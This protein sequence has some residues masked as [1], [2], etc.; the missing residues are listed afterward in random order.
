MTVSTESEF[1]NKV[2]SILNEEI[3]R[4]YVLLRN[5]RLNESQIEECIRDVFEE[6]HTRRFSPISFLCRSVSLII[7]VSKL[8]LV[9]ITIYAFIINDVSTQKFIL[10]HSQSYI[11]PFMRKLRLITIPLLNKWPSISEF[12]EEQCLVENPFFVDNQL[13]C[14]PCEDVRTVVD[15]SFLFNYSKAYVYNEKP[16]FVRDVFNESIDLQS[17]RDLCLA[18]EQSLREGTAHFKSN[19]AQLSMRQFFLNPEKYMKSDL[20]ITW[21]MSRVSAA[22]IIRKLFV[23]PHFVPESSEIALQRYLYFDGPNSMSYNF[24][25]TDFANV[26]LVQA[27]GYRLIALHPSEACKSNCTSISVLL[28]PKD[29]LYYNWQFYS[30]QSLPSKISNEMSITYLSSFY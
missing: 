4:T 27:Q 13:E 19:V 23:K 24:P 1:E 10:R 25:I 5:C 3:E 2:N 28:R 12:H 29:V 6:N 16:F 30:A 26:W 15:L 9:L 18:N 7:L 8:L 17:L 21:K 14:W 22:R 11:H 20:Q